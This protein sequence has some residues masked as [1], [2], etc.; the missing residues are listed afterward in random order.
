MIRASR[1]PLSFIAIVGVFAAFA[2]TPVQAQTKVSLLG[3]QATGVPEN[4]A[5]RCS[6]ALGRHLKDAGYTQVQGKALVE[7]KLVFGCVNE[8]A[9]C[10]A[11]V[12]EKLKADKLLWGTLSKK[13]KHYVLSLS[14]LDVAN[15]RIKKTQRRY[16]PRTLLR[17]VETAIQKIAVKL[18]PAQVGLIKLTSATQGAEVLLDGRP[19]GSINEQGL[20]MQISAGKHTLQVRREGYRAW[21]QRVVVRVGA[22]LPLRAELQL[23]DTGMGGKGDGDKALPLIPKP[24][25][26]KHQGKSRTGWKIAFYV[27]TAA[28][29]GI[30]A[31][32]VING[33]SVMKAADH[34]NDYL[35][36]K[37]SN[38]APN[39]QELRVDGCSA[40]SVSGSPIEDYCNTGESGAIIQ[41][42]LVGGIVAAGLVSA[43][44]FYKTFL[45]SDGHDEHED[46]SDSDDMTARRETETK[47]NWMV[48]P[49]ISPQG[50][51]LGVTLT[52]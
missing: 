2:T 48:S 36:S 39:I 17:D 38:Q 34:K 7:I 35:N 8:S 33:L 31:G 29:V 37:E 1:P 26:P 14:L 25:T 52:F 28:T 30:G 16:R 5:A 6:A 42:I 13:K 32:L 51:G 44:F 3:V 18:L 11:K 46:T 47:I 43:F 12:G 40:N 27:A 19:M 20:E 21:I 10:M 49:S 50:G 23:I 41:N 45:A 15:K 9:A 24:K 22:T 4:L